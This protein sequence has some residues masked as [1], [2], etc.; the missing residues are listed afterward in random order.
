MMG[1][2]VQGRYGQPLP[3]PYAG[4][5]ARQRKRAERE[6]IKRLERVEGA[7]PLWAIPL[8]YLWAG[9]AYVVSRVRGR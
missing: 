2:E 7:P 4:M 9:G 6:R 5:T 3:D 8:L 1:D